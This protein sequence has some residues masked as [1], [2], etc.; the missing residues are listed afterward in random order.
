MIVPQYWAESRVQRR[1][2]RRQVT[3]RRF[4]WSDES[5]E[6]AQRHADQRAQEA[7]NRIWHGEKLARRE[8]KL[9]YNGAQGVPIREEILNR[10]GDA[11]VTR[12]AYGARCLNTPN[13]LFVDVDDAS[14]PSAT[15]TCALILL[16]L[17]F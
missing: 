7:L 16:M 8:R 13:V 4:G 17:A 12:N 15:L 3:V 9:A 14:Q 1:E 6:A 5:Q 10:Y 11:I 2:N